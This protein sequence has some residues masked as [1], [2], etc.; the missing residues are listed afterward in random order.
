MQNFDNILSDCDLECT[1]CKDHFY[2]PV[3]TP[4]GHHF[5]K[6][7]LSIWVGSSLV[8]DCPICKY[9]FPILYSKEHIKNLKQDFFL[10]KIVRSKYSINCPFYCNGCQ[11]KILPKEETSHIRLCQYA[12]VNCSNMENGCLE[13]P[14]AKNLFNHLN[15]CQYNICPGKRY[16]CNFISNKNNIMEHLKECTYNNI[17][18]NIETL[19]IKYID[20]SNKDVQ[21]RI[22]EIL[23]NILATDDNNI[24]NRRIQYYLQNNNNNNNNSSRYFERFTNPNNEQENYSENRNNI[25]PLG[26]RRTIIPRLQTVSNLNRSHTNFIPN[27]NIES[28]D[29]NESN[30]IND[31]NDNNENNFNPTNRASISLNVGNPRIRQLSQELQQLVNIELRRN[32]IHHNFPE[33]EIQNDENLSDDLILNQQNDDPNNLPNSESSN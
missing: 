14:I 32:N 23:E 9:K 28:N 29:S 8:S 22:E 2:E 33:L 20:K 25:L 10:D 11:E 27:D 24:I 12:N 15:E 26:L 1:I 21:N 7:C 31:N 5:C 30:E 13:K 19:L 4:C 17:G 18:K 6:S 3:L 16:G